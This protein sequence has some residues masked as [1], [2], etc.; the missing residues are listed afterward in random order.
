MLGAQHQD[1]D[2]KG[3][4]NYPRDFSRWYQL[5]YFHR[6]RALKERRFYVT[7]GVT[8]ATTLLC[9][10]TVLSTRLHC[11]HQ[12]AP[13]SK[14][15]AGFNMLCA[16]C[17]DQAWQPLARL[18]GVE[19][20]S[21]S[22]QTCKSCHDGPTHHASQSAEPA[23]A[24]C[25]REH[26]GKS[27]LAQV[28]ERQ[29]TSCHAD[30]DQHM[31]PGTITAFHKTITNFNVDH[32][33]FK[34]SSAGMK[35]EAKIRFTH[36][37]HLKLD[38][39]AL[40]K[41]HPHLETKY[42]S[43]ASLECIDCHQVDSQRRYMKPIKY[44]DHCAACHQLTVTIVSDFTDAGLKQAAAKF[45]R[46]PAPHQ[47][48]ERI[49]AVLR[50]RFVQFAQLHKLVPSDAKTT[51][52]RPLPWRKPTDVSEGVWTWATGQA[53]KNE[54]LLFANQQWKK[55]SD[56]QFAQCSHC[57]IETPGP[58]RLD[59]LPSYEPT[60]IPARWYTHS[61]FNHD[62]HRMMRCDQ[63]HDQALTS[64]TTADILLPRMQRC[65]QCHQQGGLARNDC[66]ECHQYHD[67]KL[68]RSLN[69]RFTVEELLR[70]R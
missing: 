28:A 12:A 60:K 39:A 64:Q 8:L 3:S 32:P 17:H 9:L 23:C 29:C 26:Q 70:K 6:P 24:S 45:Q 57:H 25:H 15:H 66:V 30:L 2:E 7:L 59:G 44:E 46:E 34:P 33:D 36:A 54:A 40:R 50:D 19:T 41:L 69:G 22:D 37:D 31:L 48:P 11:V 61:V 56:Q 67:H 52:P 1:F 20:S 49:R 68:E 51:E 58:A 18:C 65:Q 47:E 5:D 63:C 27:L 14:A 38:L 53:Q 42:A 4:S 43:K 10:A 21:V 16:T 55:A 35:D 62:S 13:V